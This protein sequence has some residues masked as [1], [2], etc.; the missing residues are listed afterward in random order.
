MRSFQPAY[1]RPHTDYAYCAEELL[2]HTSR[3]YSYI[4]QYLADL[5]Q[6]PGFSLAGYDCRNLSRNQKKVLS[7]LMTEAPGQKSAAHIIQ[8]VSDVVAGHRGVDAELL[9]KYEQRYFCT[10]PHR[11]TPQV[12][13]SGAHLD[14]S[15]APLDPI[16]NMAH[17]LNIP[18]EI[19]GRDV[20]IPMHVLGRHLDSANAVVRQN[21]QDCIL[22]L[23]DSGYRLKDM[24]Y[25]S[26][27]QND[28][29]KLHA[30]SFSHP[31]H[32]PLWQTIC[33]WLKPHSRHVSA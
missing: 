22:L 29:Q 16:Q 28:W 6:Q 33:Q 27:S 31:S 14:V 13:G 5:A 18:I 10:H 9:Q 23:H 32:P 1:P 20:L 24:P 8:I 4:E 15:T 17:R 21:I 2:C 19:K 12:D 26:Q 11:F 25:P 30:R 3:Y 7:G